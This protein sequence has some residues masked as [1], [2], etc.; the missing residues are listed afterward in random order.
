MTLTIW[1]LLIAVIGTC[2]AVWLVQQEKIPGPFHWI[3]YAILV[4]L[5]VLVVAAALGLLPAA[6]QR[7][8]QAQEAP[9]CLG[10]FTGPTVYLNHDYGY[11][12]L[13]FEKWE[14]MARFDARG[15]KWESYMN[16]DY[17]ENSDNRKNVA[18]LQFGI[19]WGTNIDGFGRI[20][21]WNSKYNTP[22]QKTSMC[23]LGGLIVGTQ[24]MGVTWLKTKKGGGGYA[25]SF[26]GE[27]ARIE[28]VRIH[29][30]HDAFMPYRSNNFIIRHNWVSYARDDCVEN[31]GGAQGLI[32]NNLFDGCFVFYSSSGGGISSGGANNLVRIANN[33]IRME[34]M[35]GPPYDNPPTVKAYGSV[36]KIQPD[37]K[38]RP[39][40]WFKKNTVAMESGGRKN[41]LASL[42]RTIDECEG[43]KILWLGKGA[44]PY[45]EDIKGTRIE[46]CFEVI[47]G[48]AAREEWDY[49]KAKWIAAHSDIA[50]VE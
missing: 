47:S 23:F 31:D 37:E 2:V 35:P 30:H 5:W 28:R 38:D 9:G 22:A 10:S 49:A 15:G 46:H 43:N 32:A 13:K 17:A 18:P 8:A 48:M 11:E 14:D 27:G 16:G 36:L 12:T 26:N 33:L 25:I 6:S 1:G 4:V 44:F 45:W 24:P 41:A 42:Q 34:P 19:D 39:K 50:R 7:I 21:R 3:V 29:N 20:D 40:L